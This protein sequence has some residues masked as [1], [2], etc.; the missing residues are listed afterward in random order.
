MIAPAG[1]RWLRRQARDLRRVLGRRRRG[2]PPRPAR[3]W[4]PARSDDLVAPAAQPGPDPVRRARLPPRTA[5]SPGCASASSA[6]AAPTRGSAPSCPPAPSGCPTARTASPP[7]S[8]TSPS[9]SPTLTPMGAYR[10]AGRPE[11]TALL[12]RLVDHAAHELAIDPIELRRRNLLPDDVFPFP[13]LTGLTYDSGRYATPLTSP[14]RRSA[15]TRCAASRPSVGLRGDR[16]RPR[17]RRR[18][19]RRDHGGRQQQ[20]VRRRR[21]PRRRLGHG[22]GRNVRPRPGPPDGLRHARPRPDRHPDRPHPARR[23]RHR[24]RAQRRGHRRVALVADRRV[25]RPPGH[26]DCSS[27]RPSAWPPTS[28]RPTSPT[29]SSTPT[30]ARSAS[31]A[32]R[33]AP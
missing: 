8:S 1:R 28:S 24:P 7:S 20:R 4:T 16:R 22:A 3:H 11:A 29:S 21:G 6:T 5:R 19:L 14:P 15:T 23:R 25:G 30:P 27:S 26:R 32:F 31:P 12:E 18:R 10:G 2:P 9:P 33:P 13:T 17:H